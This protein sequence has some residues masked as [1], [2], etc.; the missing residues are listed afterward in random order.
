MAAKGGTQRCSHKAVH[1]KRMN[2][3]S[4][5]VFMKGRQLRCMNKGRAYKN[6]ICS[7]MTMQSNVCCT[8]WGAKGAL[9]PGRG[10][11]GTPYPWSL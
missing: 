1:A 9:N 8:N 7:Q 2:S 5:K 10:A 11:K 3:V 4:H 6:K